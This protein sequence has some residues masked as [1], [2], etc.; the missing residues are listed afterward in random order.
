M[1]NYNKVFEHENTTAV[2]ANKNNY[3][4]N[5]DQITVGG[6]SAG[7]CASFGASI[8]EN[9]DYFNELSIEQDRT[10]LSTNIEY[11]FQVH[12]IIL[13][14]GSKGCAEAIARLSGKKLY[15]KNNPP[16][17]IAHGTNDK[18]VHFNNA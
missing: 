10:L 15:K 14:W 4:V 1:N 12:S 18:L 7:G 6:G 3:G 13:L 16:V 2:I 9:E 11:K 5:T 17:F 8:T